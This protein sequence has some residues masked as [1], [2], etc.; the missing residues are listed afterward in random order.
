MLTGRQIQTARELLGWSVADLSARARVSPSAIQRAELAESAPANGL[1][2]P[3]RRALEEAGVGFSWGARSDPDAFL[4]DSPRMRTAFPRDDVH[5]HFVEEACR[6]ERAGPLQRYEAA[7]AALAEASRVDEV[8]EIRDR[9]AAMRAYARQARDREL[10]G[11]ATEIRLRA[12]RRCGELLA[13]TP[14]N[15][16]AA[17]GGARETSR[18][19][20]ALPRSQVPTLAALGVSKTQSSRWQAAA[21]LPEPEFERRLA[22]AKR[23]A[24]ASVE[25]PRAERVAEKQQ[26]RRER[27]AALALRQRALPEAKF[28]VILA[29]PEWRFEFWGRESQSRAPDLHYPTSP[30]EIIAARDV[31]AIAA[32]DAV[33]FLWATA[34]MLPDALLVMA[35]WGFAYRTHFVWIKTLAGTGYWSRNWHELLLVGVR[36]EPPAPAPGTQWPSRIEAPTAA[37]SVKPDV[38]YEL[39]EAYFPSLPKI[40]L[41]ARRARAGWARWGNEA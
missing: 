32:G 3:I 33:L 39:I 30:T 5:N 11:F 31:G 23:E 2:I 40:E 12:E 18:G 21:L 20:I 25:Q 37:H 22:A 27:E 4:R 19:R 10:I 24:V 1:A 16:G 8:K 41:N 34:P 26:R 13:L 35:A 29:D 38:F 28:G 15:P 17:G 14:K 7:R 36:G 6:G 9:A